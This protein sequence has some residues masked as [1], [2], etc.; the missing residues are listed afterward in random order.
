MSDLP[1]PAAIDKAGVAQILRDI[2][3]L[4]ELR[5]E[6]PFKS[7][8]YEK[9]ARAIES[10]PEDL[11]EL[12]A[13]GAHKKLAGIGKA[14][15]EKLEE[16][17]STGRCA[18]YEELRAS[19]PPTLIDLMSI[20]G[21]GTKKILLLHE[22][23][24]IA[25]MEALEEAIRDG[26][27]ATLAGF[28]EK[29]GAKIL[30]GIAFVR[31][32]ASQHLLIDALAEA[33]RVI[34]ALGRVVALP[35]DGAISA[36]V[37]SPSAPNGSTAAAPVAVSSSAPAVLP[38]GAPSLGS[39]SIAGSLRRS[40][41]V[42]KD[43]DLVGSTEEP[44]AVMAAFQSLP[45]A[46]RVINRG[47]TKSTIAVG[48]G[49][50]V[51]LRLVAPEEYPYALLHFTG[52]AE[53]NTALRGRAKDRGLKLNEYG[54]W[55][56]DERVAAASERDIY[57]ALG[58]AEIPPELREAM[59]EVEAAAAG[60]IPRLVQLGDLRGILHCH[61]TW[62]DGRQTL[63]EMAEGARDAG[64]EYL[65]ISDH[66]GAATYAG[67][68]TPESIRAQ[69]AEIDGLNRRLA[70]F[71]IFK[72]IESDILSDGAL[73]YEDELLAG[74]DFVVGSVHSRMK[75]SSG[76]MTERLLRAVRNP[77]LTILGHASGRRLL[78]RDPYAVDMQRVIAEAI[79][80]GVVVEHNCSPERMDLDWRYL[81]AAIPQGLRT[82]INPDAHATREYRYLELGCGTA[83]KG[84][85]E[86]RHVLNTLGVREISEY[87][88][89][90]RARAA[91]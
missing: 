51:D 46:A 39:L 20:P 30:D 45:V 64:Y 77:R 50:Q 4:L 73:D 32:H 69:W 8:A 68:L 83:R 74:F 67:G 11:G 54:L 61:S 6:N 2:A 82:S 70:P 15:A 89:A 19:L 1:A 59:G 86:P 40:K 90:R 87:F 55:R 52:S 58:L 81:R 28:G 43:I 60:Q 12:V 24:G 53:H 21:L 23:L 29:T 17:V 33:A 84:G 80:H 9:A 78:V 36:G 31:A 47:P 16:M 37:A 42:V 85:V 22:R 5:G 75:L 48:A 56:G 72:G 26:R 10:T 41:E 7:R 14:I 44:D 38:P 49:I 88:E 3:G 34:E 79:A 27:V 57:A 25:T 65:G 66:S 91:S 63:L 71:R 76:E 13:S 62:S 18:Y 35:R